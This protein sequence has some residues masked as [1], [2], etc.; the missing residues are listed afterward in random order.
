MG[1]LWTDRATRTRPAE[2][3]RFERVQTLFKILGDLKDVVLQL[4]VSIRDL[5]EVP[6]ARMCREE[7]FPAR[8]EVQHRQ[9]DGGQRDGVQ[10]G[11]QEPEL[12]QER[13]GESG[14]SPPVLLHGEDAHNI[15]LQVRG[16]HE[17]K[18]GVR[19][20]LLLRTDWQD[21]DLLFLKEVLTV[22]NFV[23]KL[24]CAPTIYISI[25]LYDIPSLIIQ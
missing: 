3:R 13:G 20:H 9:G 10:G 21:W 15:L 5:H 7:T 16:G 14:E 8:R 1:S 19:G 11:E 24:K 4:C 23:Y 22:G 18:Q 12:L 6:E 25:Y 2:I 17:V